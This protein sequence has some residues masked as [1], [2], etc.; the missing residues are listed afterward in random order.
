VH[1]GRAQLELAHGLED[2]EGVMDRELGIIGQTVAGK[3]V[4]LEDIDHGAIDQSAAVNRG[5]HIVVAIELTNQRNHRFRERFT[6]DP[7]TETLVGLLSHGQYLPHVGAEKRGYIM[8]A[9]ASM[10]NA[11]LSTPTPK[12]HPVTT[13]PLSAQPRATRGPNDSARTEST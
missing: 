8:T 4:S 3:A 9:P 5:H 11:R 13:A 12:P 2:G 10:S 6:I 1:R 7:F